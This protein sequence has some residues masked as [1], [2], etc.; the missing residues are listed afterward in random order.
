[1]GQHV[2]FPEGIEFDGYK[3]GFE[4]LWYDNNIHKEPSDWEEQKEKQSNYFDIRVVD[5]ASYKNLNAQL[6]TASIFAFMDLERGIDAAKIVKGKHFFKSYRL[7][8]IRRFIEEKSKIFQQK[9]MEKL[10]AD[11]DDETA[12]LHYL[13]F[14]S[15]EEL[16][17]IRRECIEALAYRVKVH[18][19]L[20][21][22]YVMSVIN[23]FAHLIKKYPLF[24]RLVDSFKFPPSVGEQDLY[25]TSSVPMVVIYLR[26]I[27]GSQEY[28][29]R[30]IN[31]FLDVLISRYSE[32]S[33]LVYNGNSLIHNTQVKDFIW[34]AGGNR[35]VKN[36]YDYGLDEN[37][38]PRNLLYTD[39]YVFI[40]GHEIDLSKFR[41]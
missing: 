33:S 40:R 22:E 26:F 5:W 24:G 30:M 25:G 41:Q 34:L 6:A 28:R 29:S 17:N 21:L 38:F 2:N 13:S 8:R 1:L 36:K 12:I 16:A 37:F 20:K 27:P 31:Q 18:F 9:G 10:S 7:G 39:D 4:W 14:Y 35:D 11:E 23:D 19:M 3:G 32:V 15:P